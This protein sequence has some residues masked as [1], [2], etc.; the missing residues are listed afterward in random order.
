[1]RQRLGYSES[2]SWQEDWGEYRPISEEDRSS[3]EYRDQDELIRAVVYYC[4]DRQNFDQLTLHT[5][6][7]GYV[8]LD[9]ATW[10]SAV[11]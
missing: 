11:E 5:R 10:H 7:A 9:M 6:L 3:I 8:T 2:G 4:K 1:M